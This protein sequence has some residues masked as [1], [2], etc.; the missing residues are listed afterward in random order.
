MGLSFHY[1]GRIKD[2][3]LIDELTEEV[4]DICQDLEWDFKIIGQQDSGQPGG[5]CFSPKDCEPVFLTFLPGGRICSPFS[6]NNRSFY[7]VHCLDPEMIYVISTNT[8]YAGPEV[9][10]T[11]MKLLRYLAEKYFSVFELS[12]EGMY[13]ETNDPVILYRRFS[14]YTCLLSTVTEVVN[15]M[16][17]IPGE[18]ILSLVDRIEK[19]WIGR[20]AAAH[21]DSK[22]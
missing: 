3:D 10:L 5:I 18:T 2:P 8:Q 9:H 19:L 1:S 22:G 7:Q 21:A 15:T 4:V 11:L 12:D 6:F 20:L 13:W 16:K 14:E 17:A